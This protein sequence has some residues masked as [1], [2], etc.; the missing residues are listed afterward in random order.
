VDVNNKTVARPFGTRA[1]KQTCLIRAHC[2]IVI[3]LRYATIVLYYTDYCGA[4]LYSPVTFGKIGHHSFF[5][6][7]KQGML[8]SLSSSQRQSTLDCRYLTLLCDNLKKR[9][10]LQRHYFGNLLCF[11]RYPHHSTILQPYTFIM[12]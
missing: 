7:R 6:E 4:S 12:D 5:R 9:M 11:S 2:S 10:S 1:N 3:V 8:S